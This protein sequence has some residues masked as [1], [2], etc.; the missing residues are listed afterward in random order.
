MLRRKSA[1]WTALFTVPLLLPSYLTYTG[2]GMLRAPGS[3]LGSWLAHGSP[4]R[5]VI[6]NAVLAI[7]GLALWAW[8]IGAFIIS[9]WFRQIP[10]DLLDLLDLEP[11][12]LWRKCLTIGR[13]ALPGV[14]ASIGV[15]AVIMAGSAIP[16]HLAQVQTYAIHLWLYLSL[17]SDPASVWPAAT[18]L[19]GLALA[20]A[21]LISLRLARGETDLHQDGDADRPARSRLP[22][23]LAAAVW[24]A[25]VLAPLVLMATHLR[26]AQSIAEFW[27]LS[28]PAVVGSGLVAVL[29]GATCALLGVCTFGAATCIR[30]TA[31]RGVL[32]TATTLAIGAAFVPGILV[33]QAVLTLINGPWAP[34]GLGTTDVPLIIAHVARFGFVGVIAGWLLVRTESA[35]ERGARLLASGDTVRGWAMLR[36]YPNLAVLVGVGLA[37]G[38]LSLHEIESTVMLAR[39]GSANIAQYMLDRLH[40]ARDE[41]LCAACVNMIGI[42]IVLSSGAAMLLSRGYRRSVPGLR[43]P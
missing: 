8:P 14:A 11:V 2:W 16:L 13:V 31:R 26:H 40:Y 3:V 32:W 37:A 29:V 12:G 30:G 6:L 1:L 43:T 4:D 18:P 5:A 24:A 27:R 41:E 9:P 39:P 42:G 19:L 17:T 28:G 36:L 33:G 10:T 15:I 7:G 35:E 20:A 38:A 34:F 25:S 23:L 21:V 22:I